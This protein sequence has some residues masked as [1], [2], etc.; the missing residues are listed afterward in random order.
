LFSCRNVILSRVSD[1]EDVADVGVSS[2]ALGSLLQ[3][4]HLLHLQ[5]LHSSDVV[6]QGQFAV[7]G[8]LAE[9]AVV[10]QPVVKLIKTFFLSL[11]DEK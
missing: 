8:E 3:L 9:G 6:H 11:A 2:V 1:P 10:G 7:A 5:V 4:V